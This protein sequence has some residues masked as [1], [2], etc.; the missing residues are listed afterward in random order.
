M[1]ILGLLC[2]LP[3]ATTNAQHQ[4]LTNPGFESVAEGVPSDWE[5]IPANVGYATDQAYA[6]DYALKLEAPEASYALAYQRQSALPGQ[7]YTGS[8]WVRSG[9]GASPMTL[10][11]EFHDDT[12]R[13]LTETLRPLAAPPDWGHFYLFATAPEGAAFVT[14]TLVAESMEPVDVDETRLSVLA[15]GPALTFNLDRLAQEFQ[16]F[17]TQLWAHGDTVEWPGQTARRVQALQDFDIRFV[18]VE[19]YNEQAATEDLQALR[20]TTDAL[21]I[22]WLYMLWSAPQQF[23][24]GA[25]RLNDIPGFASWWAGH[26]AALR[27]QGVPVEYIELMNEPDSDGQWSTGI[28]SGQYADLAVQVRAALDQAGLGNTGIIGPGLSSTSWSQPGL[29]LADWGADAAAAH[30]GVSTHTWADDYVGGYPEGPVSTAGYWDNLA[31][32]AA[33]VAP[34][35]PRFVTEYATRQSDYHGVSYRAPDDS[36]WDDALQFPY[37]NAT[38]TTPYALRVFANTLALLNARR[39]ANGLFLWQLLDEPTE[40]LGKNKG[41]GM[42]DLW[43]HDK[44]VATAMRS[45]LPKIPAGSRVVNS[46]PQA[47]M[48]TYTSVLHTPDQAI[49]VAAV[50]EGLERETARL[51]LL[52]LEPGYE[53]VEAVGYRHSF[54]GDPKLGEPDRGRIVEVQARLRSLG[55]GRTALVIPMAAQS[56]A[57]ITL[58]PAAV[59]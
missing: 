57:T 22:E 13:K 16:G 44:P 37:H 8:A 58:R 41:W 15:Q 21:D 38:N 35:L 59:P 6:G 27:D 56:T 42:I 4:L 2:A 53:V 19:N 29:Y 48:P 1:K 32:A 24:N 23:A 28:D 47:F 9:T 46:P 52:N 7:H 40:V 26:L 10:K 43:G 20:A 31:Q 50:N 55:G 51:M 14:L 36:P 45:L 17:G 34:G 54:S 18:R 11:L 49:V 25:N 3:V 39:G 30:T 33:A 5:Y 12:E